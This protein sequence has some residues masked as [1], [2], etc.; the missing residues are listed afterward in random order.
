M[1]QSQINDMDVVQGEL[2]QDSSPASPTARLV[3]NAVPPDLESLT[4]V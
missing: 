3:A 4:T 1:R 2:N